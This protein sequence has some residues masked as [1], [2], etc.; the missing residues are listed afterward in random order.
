ML[1]MSISVK[2]DWLKKYPHP[3]DLLNQSKSLACWIWA[4]MGDMSRQAHFFQGFKEL[5]IS[6]GFKAIAE[7]A[8]AAALRLAHA[9][10]SFA[11]ARRPNLTRPLASSSMLTWVSK[12]CSKYLARTWRMFCKCLC[13]GTGP[14]LG[15]G[16]ENHEMLHQAWNQA[17]KA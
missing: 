13:C 6:Y 4:K 2:L 8:Y 7:D 15:G 14:T 10:K 16:H 1:H 12:P 17:R 11:Y 5:P 9:E 3:L